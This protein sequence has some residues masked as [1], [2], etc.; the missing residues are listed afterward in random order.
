MRYKDCYGQFPPQNM[1]FS[2][3]ANKVAT[4]VYNLR[5]MGFQ[6]I[7]KNAYVIYEAFDCSDKSINNTYFLETPELFDITLSNTYKLFKY[8]GFKDNS[9]EVNSNLF[10]A[11][12]MCREQIL[13]RISHLRRIDCEDGDE[14]AIDIFLDAKNTSALYYRFRSFVLDMTPATI[15]CSIDSYN[16]T[17]NRIDEKLSD[18]KAV[19][20]PCKSYINLIKVKF[21]DKIELSTS[22]IITEIP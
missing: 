5:D 22:S 17:L 19:N 16:K 1:K 9:S 2:T 21:I 13:K 10:N 20:I 6:Y 11:L 14:D 18:I 7:H 8:L 15:E 3:I 12:M 4:F